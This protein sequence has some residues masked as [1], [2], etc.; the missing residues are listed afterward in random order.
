MQPGGVMMKNLSFIVLVVVAGMIFADS[1][2]LFEFPDGRTVALT[3]SGEITMLAETFAAPDSEDP[4]PF[5][6]PCQ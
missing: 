3:S 4:R 6:A 1:A 5:R 2:V